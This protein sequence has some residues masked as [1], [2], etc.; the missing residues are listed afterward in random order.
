MHVYVHSK[1]CLTD[2]LKSSFRP[3][4]AVLSL[5]PS[6]TIRPELSRS[7]PCAQAVPE[8]AAI[9]ASGAAQMSALASSDTT[10]ASISSPG[11][12]SIANSTAGLRLNWDLD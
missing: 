5:V 4:P 12:Q 3:Y 8:F 9:E 2:L 11:S 1:E 10:C 7:P 6:I